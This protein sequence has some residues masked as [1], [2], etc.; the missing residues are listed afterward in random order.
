VFISTHDCF[1]DFQGQNLYT[2]KSPTFPMYANKKESQFFIFW[3]P[4]YSC[5]PYFRKLQP[6]K[7]NLQIKLFEYQKTNSS[8]SHKPMKQA[9]WMTTMSSLTVLCLIPFCFL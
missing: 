1:G 9:L 8:R 4:C 3:N 6:V 7:A 5:C 2:L